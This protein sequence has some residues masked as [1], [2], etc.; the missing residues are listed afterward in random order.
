MVCFPGDSTTKP[1]CT[2]LF[3]SG[4]CVKT[5]S[6]NSSQISS[7]DWHV[8]GTTLL[9]SY[10]GNNNTLLDMRMQRVLHRLRGHQN[11]CKNFIRAKFGPSSLVVGGSEDAL[12]YL[13]DANS[14]AVVE[15]LA[16]HDGVVYDAV[17]SPSQQMLAS[18]GD[19]GT[20]RTWST[21]PASA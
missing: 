5:I 12:V 6:P 8:N 19:E 1:L 7:V 9:I 2:R 21:V 18:C 20:I 4:V 13:W 15:T 16:G 14:G 10:R 11:T 3:A 17:W